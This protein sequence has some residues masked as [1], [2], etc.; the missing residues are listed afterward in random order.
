MI[1]TFVKNFSFLSIFII[2][3]FVFSC[4]NTNDN[5]AYKEM[6]QKNLSG[7]EL[8]IQLT[9]FETEHSN[10]FESKVD[11]ASFY[12]LIG[13][14]SK[15]YE[16]CVRAESVI[17]NAPKNK[18]GK[19]AICILN[20]T[21]AKV[22]YYRGDFDSAMEFCNTALK[23]KVNG[24]VFAN[25]KGQILVSMNKLDEALEVFDTAYTENPD[26]ATSED[27]KSYMYL[28]ATHDRLDKAKLIL[29]RY[30]E[31]GNYFSEF[32]AFASSV[33]EKTNHFDLS[34]L[35]TFYDYLFY[36]N[37]IPDAEKKYF[38]NLDTLR[39][40][41]KKSGQLL[42]YEESINFIESYFTLDEKVNLNSDFF[43]SQFIS[44]HKRIENKTVTQ[45]DLQTLLKMEKHFSLFPCFYWNVYKALMIVLPSAQD[46]PAVLEKVISLDNGNIFME[47]ARTELGKYIGLSEK[48]SR[49]LLVASEVDKVI[50]NYQKSL[51]TDELKPLFNLLEMPENSYE[52]QTLVYLKMEYKNL[53]LESAFLKERALCSDKLGERIDYILN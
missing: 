28:L 29:E 34:L 8:L 46:V 51:N 49:H 31:T 41:L 4:N 22:D 23:D 9:K 53:G 17:K 7:E 43:I 48:D 36:S 40:T 6:L 45:N 10:H 44:I 26:D 25:L 20:G 27:L 21:R 39:E 11:L 38:S 13:N 3:L 18:D 15:A 35:S 50:K 47:L 52:L 19:K 14:Y 37:F 33:Y 32:G 30:F 24:K 5:A 42:S 2:S 1:L 12:A 16:Y